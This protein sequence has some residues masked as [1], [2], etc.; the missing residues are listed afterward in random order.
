MKTVN[1]DPRQLSASLAAVPADKP[2]IMVNLLK[3][4]EV[5]AY[6]DGTAGCSGKKAYGLYAQALLT[7]L[8]EIGAEVVYLGKVNGTLIGPADEGW[9]EVL[10]VKYPSIAAFTAMIDSPAYKAVVKHRTAAL[11]DSRL[12][13]TSPLA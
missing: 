5:A 1:P 6:K 10:L 11:A 12:I 2:V 4:K 13:A 9:D 7:L 3:F 8:K